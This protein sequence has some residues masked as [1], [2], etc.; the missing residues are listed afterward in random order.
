MKKIFFLF[1]LILFY[2]DEFSKNWIL[3]DAKLEI[4]FN[5]ETSLLNIKDKRSNKL[6][7]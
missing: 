1:V 2:T 6:W 3:E 4:N 7:Q 5:D